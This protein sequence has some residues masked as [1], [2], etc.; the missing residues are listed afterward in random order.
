MAVEIAIPLFL[1]KMKE[2]AGAEQ[3]Q[4]QHSLCLYKFSLDGLGLTKENV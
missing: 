1:E 4:A 2:Q 3:G